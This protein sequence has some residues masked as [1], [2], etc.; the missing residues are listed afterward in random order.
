MDTSTPMTEWHVEHY[1][2][3]YTALTNITNTAQY[4]YYESAKLW[5]VQV[6]QRPDHRCN[7]LYTYIIYALPAMWAGIYGRLSDIHYR[8]VAHPHGLV[9]HCQKSNYDL[10]ALKHIFTL[11]IKTAS[12]CLHLQFLDI[13]RLHATNYYLGC[14]LQDIIRILEIVEGVPQL[15]DWAV[16]LL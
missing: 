8:Y 9:S 7:E 6:W 12:V 3:V 2:G 10:A 15:L 5:P 4:I 1:Q 14:F 13:H 16:S 11:T